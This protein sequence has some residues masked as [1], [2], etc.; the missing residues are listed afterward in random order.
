MLPEWVWTSKQSRRIGKH[1]LFDEID[2]WVCLCCQ[3]Q[4]CKD[5]LKAVQ[6]AIQEAHLIEKHLTLFR[7]HS[8]NVKPEEIWELYRGDFERHEFIK[9]CWLEFKPHSSQNPKEEVKSTLYPKN[10]TNK[11]TWRFLC[12]YPD[13]HFCRTDR[14]FS[15]GVFVDPPGRVWPDFT[16]PTDEL[17]M[18]TQGEFELE[19]NGKILRP[20]VGEEVLI[21]AR[22]LHTVTNNG[23]VTNEWLY[24]YKKN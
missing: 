13:C 14:G 16:H 2:A 12:E 21:P 22:A 11:L 10:G 4:D 15:F 23:S 6:D 8:G 24:G 5:S 7:A 20:E 19:F 1:F 18:L 3:C 17:V 9:S